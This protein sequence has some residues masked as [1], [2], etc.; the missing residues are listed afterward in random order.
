MNHYPDIP[1]FPATDPWFVLGWL[2]VLLI[3]LLIYALVGF[4]LC[5]VIAKT[6]ES[7]FKRIR[8]EHWLS[9]EPAEG[10]TW[11]DD[12]NRTYVIES[13][14]A[15]DRRVWVHIF[16]AVP[17]PEEPL[18]IDPNLPLD[19]VQKLLEQD[20]YGRR[21]EYLPVSEGFDQWRRRKAQFKLRR[22]RDHV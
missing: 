21:K 17:A 12:Q 7:V 14:N 13:V 8:R 16:H 4:P 2:L 19:D 18:V 6:G 22:E 10:Q 11:M 9:I 5:V 3:A 15:E 1:F 20:L